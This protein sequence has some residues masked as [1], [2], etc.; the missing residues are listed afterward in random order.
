MPVA[1]YQTDLFEKCKG[2][3]QFLSDCQKEADRAQHSKLA[4]ISF[5]LAPIAP[6]VLLETLHQP[7]QVYFY[8]DDV[9]QPHSVVGFDTA[10]A[11]QASGPSRFARIQQ[12]IDVWRKRILY[13]E[14]PLANSMAQPSA[15]PEA[16]SQ[17][18]PYFCCGFTFFED[19][20][21]P[22]ALFAAA[23]VFVPGLQIE[24][25]ARQSVVSFN[26]LIDD[27]NNV[28]RLTEEVGQQLQT[29]TDLAEQSRGA[30]GFGDGATQ[31]IFKV[32]KDIGDFRQAVT[33]ALS[34]IE[35]RSSLHKVVLAEQ[36]EVLS[37]TAFNVPASLAVLRYKHP[38][39]RIFSIGNGQG[40]AFMGASPERLLSI[41]HGHLKTDALAGSA[42]RGQTSDSDTRLGQQL[43][44]SDKERYEHRVV[45]EF[46]AEQLRS[47]GLLPE[48]DEQPQLLRLSNIQHL[49]TPIRAQLYQT[50]DP[51]KILAQLHPTPA[52]AGLP[53]TEASDLIRQTESFGRGLYA[54]PIGWV[55]AEGN[56]EFVVGIRSALINGR[57]AR[58]YA[59]AGVVIGS[60]PGRETAE[61]KLKLQALLGSLV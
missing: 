48:F 23:Q 30:S 24:T 15:T 14:A 51:L 12:F 39:C 53:R 37:A 59:G 11:Y 44:L 60:D 7:D 22:D 17:S 13:G 8:Y 56:S 35:A 46:I 49:H 45:V 16:L 47:L 5:T 28:A 10:I 34:A 43:L 50:T 2:V 4:T 26:C 21:A 3:Y 25:N 40:Q 9:A 1:P 42:P 61:I 57:Q 27:A 31:R 6:W 33:T 32:V 58:L 36:M 41:R 18:S 38:A 55:D 29:I 20:P 52:V 19:T 54:A